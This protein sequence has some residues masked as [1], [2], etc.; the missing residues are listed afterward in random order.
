MQITTVLHQAIDI[1]CIDKY[2]ILEVGQVK[3][4]WYVEPSVW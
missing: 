4:S 1:I 3:I 2:K